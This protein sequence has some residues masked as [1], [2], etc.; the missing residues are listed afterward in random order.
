MSVETRQKLLRNL[1]NVDRLPSLPVVVTPLIQYLDRPIDSLQV[2][3]V[4]R[5]ISQ[6][7]SLT[8]QCLHLANSPLFGRWQ[9]VE[10]V[11]GAVVS[12]GLR[13]MR[14]IVTSCF[15]LKLMPSDCPVDP[16]VFWEH[17][18]GVA[19]AGRHF[20]REIGFPG[21][22]KVYLAGLLHDFGVIMN[23]WLVPKECGE[24]FAL[25]RSRQIPLD[26]AEMECLG[27]AHCEIGRLLAEKWHMP[28]DISQVI[29]W[30]HQPEKAPESRE[31][32]ALVSL[33]DL[34]CRMSG[35]GYGYSENR[36]IVFC[37]QPAFQVLL[38][39]CPDLRKFDW[40]RFTFEMEGYLVE[41]ERL[42]SLVY[43]PT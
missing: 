43:R 5:L 18:L 40:E 36:Q 20:A 13:R 28:R 19:L 11:R 7:E 9:P 15:L 27:V 41:V 29:A 2:N 12:L 4:A 21:P 35:I 26:E 17:A 6:D 39:A 34:L 24:T 32:V 42:V 22:D 8:A 25:A 23:F 14:E 33:A 10:T 1:E 38:D 3:E 31:L 16:T 30:H 37:Q